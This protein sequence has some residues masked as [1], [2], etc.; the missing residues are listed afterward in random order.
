[1]AGLRTMIQSGSEIQK[2]SY[3]LVS[4]SPPRPTIS[5]TSR[6]LFQSRVSAR[7]TLPTSM[8][9]L[10]TGTTD[11]GALRACVSPAQPY[12]FHALWAL[13]VSPNQNHR[14]YIRRLRERKLWYDA[15]PL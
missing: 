13:L 7:R 2:N 3:H 10:G 4:G 12:I 11:K 6:T 14:F 1:M 15:I 9:L 8:L 5:E